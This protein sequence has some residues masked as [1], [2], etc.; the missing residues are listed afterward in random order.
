MRK[1]LAIALAFMLILTLTACGGEQPNDSG[2]ADI[3]TPTTTTTPI[4]TTT[5]PVITTTSE[6]VVTT[7][8]PVTAPP[9]VDKLQFGG[10]NWIVLERSGDKALI[11]SENILERRSIHNGAMVNNTITWV[12]CDLRVYLNSEFYNSFDAADRARIIET[13]IENINPQHYFDAGDY[14]DA[15]PDTND[16]IFILSLTE[17]QKYFVNNSA[18]IANYNDSPQWWY[19]RTPGFY[20]GGNSDSGKFAFIRENGEI[21]LEFSG[22]N[23]TMF[24][25]D[26]G[27]FGIR[28]A[29]WIT[30]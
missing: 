17:V 5:P 15:G 12:D 29:M 16:K 23:M 28:P 6:P 3:T 26:I 8:P 1:F 2:N 30:L 20:M 18:S 11:V 19:L 27:G 9:V 7:T 14:A 4:T 22:T 25:H 13:Q 24:D 10:Y 21:A